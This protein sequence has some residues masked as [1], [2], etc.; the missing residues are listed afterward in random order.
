MKGTELI[1]KGLPDLAVA[2]KEMFHWHRASNRCMSYRDL[3]R[4]SNFNLTK[5]QL[6][7]AQIASEVELCADSPCSLS[8]GK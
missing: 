5:M 2:K 3:R 6:T 4:F 1:V 7:D 8:K